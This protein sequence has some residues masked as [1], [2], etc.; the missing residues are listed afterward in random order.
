MAQ[1]Q[2]QAETQVKG[3]GQATRVEEHSIMK[4][5]VSMSPINIL[6]IIT[7]GAREQSP[8]SRPPSPFFDLCKHVLYLFLLTNPN[9]SL[10]KTSFQPLMW[11]FHQLISKS[12]PHHL[13]DLT[14]MSLE[15]KDFLYKLLAAEGDIFKGCIVELQQFKQFRMK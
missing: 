14:Q 10:S 6:P 12:K 1:V 15:E 7:E 11:R 13:K 9:S 5:E 8:I 2:Q 3:Q 4:A